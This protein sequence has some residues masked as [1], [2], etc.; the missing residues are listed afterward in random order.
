MREENRPPVLQCAF[1]TDLY[2][3]QHGYNPVLQVVKVVRGSSRT[4]AEA[5]II[6][7][8]SQETHES[9]TRRLGV[10]MVATNQLRVAL[11]TMRFYY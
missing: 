9:E 5:A 6:C 3:I 8:L 10:D 7:R 11:R 4:G 1:V 2:N